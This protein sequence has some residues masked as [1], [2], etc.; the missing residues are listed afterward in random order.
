MCS[1]H[2]ALKREL[3]EFHNWHCSITLWANMVKCSCIVME[4]LINSYKDISGRRFKVLK[5]NCFVRFSVLFQL[6]FCF[7]FDL[8]LREYYWILLCCCVRPGRCCCL[9][10]AYIWLFPVSR[11]PYTAGEPDHGMGQRAPPECSTSFF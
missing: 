1:N 10:M 6:Q 5:T 3:W 11:E 4:M 9:G 8:A 2:T 7:V